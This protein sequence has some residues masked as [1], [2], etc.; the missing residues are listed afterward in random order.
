VAIGPTAN[1]GVFSLFHAKPSHR[2]IKGEISGKSRGIEE[3]YGM[4]RDYSHLHQTYRSISISI[5]GLMQADDGLMIS[6]LMNGLPNVRRLII[7]VN[8]GTSLNM[9]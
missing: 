1:F 6:G 9:R 3:I 7:E 4:L 2:S 8:W 5:N